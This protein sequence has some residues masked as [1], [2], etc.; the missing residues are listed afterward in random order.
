MSSR[1]GELQYIV[2]ASVRWS[3]ESIVSIG[4]TEYT[5]QS[6]EYIVKTS[7]WWS[8]KSV[9]NIW[10][11]EY[12]IHIKYR[13]ISDDEFMVEA[14]FWWSWEWFVIICGSEYTT[15]YINEC[16]AMN[17]S[18][19]SQLNEAKKYDQIISGDSNVVNHI[20][21]EQCDE[22]ILTLNRSEEKLLQRR[23]SY[24]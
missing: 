18:L 6:Y 5:T 10:I 11:A 20:P 3:R 19:T 8:W 7:I 14:C 1:I 15:S 16:E 9:V 24:G 13:R 2:K 23:V 12:I 21:L 17:V 4:I 22:L